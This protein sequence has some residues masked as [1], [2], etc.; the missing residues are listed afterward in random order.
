MPLALIDEARQVRNYTPKETE[1]M[2][3]EK[4]EEKRSGPETQFKMQPDKRTTRFTLPNGLIHDARNVRTPGR[5]AKCCDEAVKLTP[6]E[7][8]ILRDIL[9]ALGT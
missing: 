6:M 5:I 3:E 1:T 4:K 8:H 7:R 9:D 2:S